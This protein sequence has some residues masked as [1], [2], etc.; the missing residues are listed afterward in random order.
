MAETAGQI[1]IFEVLAAAEADFEMQRAVETEEGFR[2]H[3]PFVGHGNL[4]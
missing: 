3:R 2:R 4:R 1:D